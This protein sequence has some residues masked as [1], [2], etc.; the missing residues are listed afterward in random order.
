VLRLRVGDARIT[1]LQE[2]TLVGRSRSCDVRLRDDTVSRLHA[3]FTWNDGR[4]ILEDLGSSN[5]TYVNGA[6]LSDAIEVGA[7]DAIRFGGVA[8]LV[9]SPATTECSSSP[10]PLERTTE[11][12]V[13][14]LIP[15]PPAGLARRLLALFL[16]A[17]LFTLGSLVP[18]APLIAVLATERFLF[19]PNAVAASGAVKIAAAAASIVLGAAYLCYYVVYG[20]GRR[21]GTPGLLL[22]GLRLVDDAMYAPIGQV[23]AWV[24]FGAGLLTIATLGLGFLSVAF[25]HDRKALHDILAGTLVVE[26]PRGR[27]PRAGHR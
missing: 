6:R 27:E 9:E 14:G 21:A 5:G 24:R 1:L 15:G 2:R 10:S 3:A 8:A 13:T 23:R 26:R 22:T 19:G 25:R 18:M 20:W 12:F 16:D 17:V 4:L 7:G 11:T